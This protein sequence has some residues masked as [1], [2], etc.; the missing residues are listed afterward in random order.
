LERFRPTERQPS[1]A[2]QEKV[3]LCLGRLDPRKRVDLLVQATRILARR[4][5]DFHV[6][7]VGR[8]GYAPGWQ[9]LVTDA[10]ATLPISY[11]PQVP[12]A[13]AARMLAEARVAVQASENEEFGH[14]VAEALASG[15]QVVIGP[16]NH[17]AEYVLEG[18]GIVFARYEPEALARALDQALDVG[19]EVATERCRAAAEA[20][21]T[22][23]NITDRLENAIQTWLELSRS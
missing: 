6:R 20:A 16:S 1:A 9:Q 13:E 8:S 3:V 4:R 11:S 7:V 10:E 15:T 19:V 14:A 12:Q 22:V 18:S 5:S 23:E 21:F 2:G 17:T